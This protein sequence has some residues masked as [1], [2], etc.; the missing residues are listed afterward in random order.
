MRYP[1][2][3]TPHPD[4]AASATWG[5]LEG[6][7]DFSVVV[8]VYNSQQS[9]EELHRRLAA[10][11]TAMGRSF[12]VIYTDDGSR[13]GSLQVLRGLRE[14]HPGEV[15]VVSLY[16]NQGQ[17]A[18]LMCGFGFCRG[19][20][21]VTI[22]DDLQHYPE[23]IPGMYEVL[24]DGNDAVFG[25]YEQKAHGL[26][27]NL[28]SRMFGRLNRRIFGL[29]RGLQLSA[30][31]LIR[32]GVVDH[33]IEHRTSYPYVTGMIAST[34]T[35][36]ANAPVRHEARRYGKSGYTLGRLVRLSLNLLINYSAI[37]L[38]TVAWVGMGTSLLA[39]I[40]GAVFAIRQLLIGLAPEGWTSLA[41]LISLFFGIMFAMMFV[42]AEY[43]S[44][45]LTEI[46]DRPAAPIREIL[47]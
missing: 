44:R 10:T 5:R 16:R 27:Q 22:D 26:V 43:L 32:R 6:R 29:P 47:Q 33:I 19:D 21:V 17:H 13:D 18:A 23:D 38:K 1:E 15:R 2:I 20:V 3:G 9:L 30:Y 12:E 42:M 36:I 24:Q 4:Q 25:A 37:P 28:G 46:S 40:A 11:F 8:P 34:T 41:V 14:R 31:R 45:L 35:R 7:V 39:F